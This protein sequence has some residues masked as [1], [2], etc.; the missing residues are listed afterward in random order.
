M[1]V[2][3]ISV[4]ALLAALGACTCAVSAAD[5]L[6]V[7]GT[8]LAATGTRDDVSLILN[9]AQNGISGYNVTFTLEDPTVADITGISFPS[10]V[11]QGFSFSSA[12]SN[13]RIV[14]VAD[15]TD[16]IKIRAANA[17]LAS[18]TITGRRQAC[19]NITVTV[20]RMDDD[21][22]SAM[23][24]AVS[25]GYIS[26][27]GTAGSIRVNTTPVNA[28]IFVDGVNS[29]VRTNNSVSNIQPGVHT[30]K[31]NLSG[32][33]EQ[34]MQVTVLCGG[35]AKADF[36][37]L[38]RPGSLKVL[39]AP[40][41]AEIFIDGTD[42]Y[43]TTNTSTAIGGLAPGQRQV[44][45]TK[46]RYLSQTN[47]VTIV[48]NVPSSITFKLDSTSNEPPYGRISV[49][50]LPAGATVI[51]D[52]RAKTV[53]TPGQIEVDPGTH[54]V[55]VSL[56][57]YRTPENQTV[58]D[59]QAGQTVPVSFSLGKNPSVPVKVK[60]LPDPMNTQHKGK[61]IAFVTLPKG[62][63]AADV[64]A[65][66]VTC[67]GAPA[68]KIIRHRLFPTVLIALFNR[69]DLKVSPG[70]HVQMQV[71]GL[72]SKGGTS[73]EF[74]GYDTIKVFGKPD[75]RHEDTDDLDR[76]DDD[77]MFRQFNPGV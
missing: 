31:V 22:G 55:T 59:I 5:S 32:Y 54:N 11:Q 46:D 30:V 72:I 28:Y 68:I 18:A 53:L 41:G 52:G 62:Y 42:Q 23:N 70:D 39:S 25:Q 27:G 34:T 8:N 75:N 29:S 36:G 43:R 15:V 64:K 58:N 24:P 12:G 77:R 3:L 35:T 26:V 74:R 4:L 61:F 50:S 13:N 45:V 51:I 7:S 47:P 49:D 48:S 14:K 9:S 73:I 6:T 2:H 60:I 67:E 40:D 65:N 38:K 66:S 19:T 37:S 17:N 69:A 33:V 56:A 16:A 10:W 63:K 71:S 44:T 57:G 76:M 1:K 20:N 21:F